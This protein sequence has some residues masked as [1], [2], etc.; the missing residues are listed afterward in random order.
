MLG[1]QFTNC[2]RL[3]FYYNRW[4][5]VLS[6]PLLYYTLYRVWVCVVINIENTEPS[7]MFGTTLEACKIT[8]MPEPYSSIQIHNSLID[9]LFYMFLLYRAIINL[10]VWKSVKEWKRFFTWG[11]KKSKGYMILECSL[12]LC[13][14]HRYQLHLG[15]NPHQVWNRRTTWNSF[16]TMQQVTLIMA[17]LWEGDKTG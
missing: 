11:G 17:R 5:T 3:Q 8:P 2:G 1:Y 12:S 13:F 14:R 6:K 15:I 10:K 7:I 16:P 4:P 9:N